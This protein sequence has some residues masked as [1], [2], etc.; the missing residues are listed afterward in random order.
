[1]QALKNHSKNPDFNKNPVGDRG[2]FLLLYLR[3]SKNKTEH[4]PW[5]IFWRAL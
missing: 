4:Y 3:P 2:I 5:L 1:M